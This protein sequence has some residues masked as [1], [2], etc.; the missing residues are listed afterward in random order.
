MRE[1]SGEASGQ[2]PVVHYGHTDAK[3]MYYTCHVSGVRRQ[4]G[5]NMTTYF[6]MRTGKVLVSC[7]AIQS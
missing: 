6:N 4:V 2:G 7:L 3:V 5:I 1:N